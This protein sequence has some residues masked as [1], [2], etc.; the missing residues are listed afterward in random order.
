[1]RAEIEVVDRV[2]PFID[3]HL[4][5]GVPAE[6]RLRQIGLLLTL[7][8]GASLIAGD[9]NAEPES[10]ELKEFANS[11][12]RDAERR[13]YAEASG[14][15]TNWHAGP[16]VKPPTQRLDYLLVRDRVTVTEAGVPEDWERWAPLSD[17][18]PLVARLG[19]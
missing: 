10:A 9:L 12:W 18:L 5:A 6:E 15:S 14:P 3:V 7:A 13:M 2:V 16:R 17:H 19:L 4:G 1:M 11:G 8:G